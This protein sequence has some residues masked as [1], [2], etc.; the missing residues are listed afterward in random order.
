MAQEQ[1]AAFAELGAAI[2]KSV[3]DVLPQVEKLKH[4]YVPYLP[5]LVPS[6]KG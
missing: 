2:A 6:T 1:T 5:P 4:S 3:K